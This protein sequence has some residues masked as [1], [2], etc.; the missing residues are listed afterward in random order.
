MSIR[1]PTAHVRR[2][3]FHL[4]WDNSIPPIAT[5]ASGDVV[6]IDALDA[7]CGQLHADSTVE[8]IRALDFARVDQVNGPIAVE[9]AEV[10]DTLEI[11][12]LDLQP[13]DWGWTA[14]IPGFGLLA[15]DFPHPIIKT[16][17]LSS[18][19]GQFAPGIEI[20]LNP[21]C[22]EMGVAPREPGALSTIPPG[23]HGGNMDTRHITAGAKLYLPVLA[24]GAL[25]SLGDGHAAQGDGEVCGTAIETPMEVKVRLTV[26]K[27][28]HL[29]APEFRTAGPLA[30]RTNVGP[31]YATDGL[32]P[33]LYVA[34]QDAVRRMIEYLGR[35][36][37]V[38]PEMAYLL[39]SVAADLKISEIV[40]APNWIVTAYMPLSIFE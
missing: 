18:D 40:D 32:G 28:L 27:D 37:G 2:D 17:Q 25:F 26:R 7:S 19:S 10:G 38:Q 11:E 31:H 24:P 36:H 21:F 8:D 3:Q 20:P 23:L 34:A 15:P 29:A 6:T 22:G 14:S 12:M 16:W 1:V 39:C 4:A 13:A 35:E 30:A 5:V 33:D 9:G